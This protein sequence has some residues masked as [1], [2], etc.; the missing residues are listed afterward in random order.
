MPE[1]EI[2]IQE[3]VESEVYSKI[4]L[5]SLREFF[6]DHAKDFENSEGSDD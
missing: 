2:T 4:C 3:V 5:K 6:I 1:Q